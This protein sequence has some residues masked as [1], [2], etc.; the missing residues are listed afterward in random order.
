MKTKLV[1][2][3]KIFPDKTTKKKKKKSRKVLSNKSTSKVRNAIVDY[4]IEIVIGSKNR[5]NNYFLL[6]RDK[7]EPN[8][9]D[10][11]MKNN[12]GRELEGKQT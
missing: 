7:M 1:Y 4:K 6:F 10:N 3:P 11:N 9:L 12:D 5:S 2:Y 8:I